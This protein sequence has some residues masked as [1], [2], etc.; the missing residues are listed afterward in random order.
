MSFTRFGASGRQIYVADLG[1]SLLTATAPGLLTG[2]I[3]V[4]VAFPETLINAADPVNPE[5]TLTNDPLPLVELA[6]YSSW[7]VDGSG[8]KWIVF[9]DDRDIL[10]LSEDRDTAGVLTRDPTEFVSTEFGGY[11]G[12]TYRDQTPAVDN[13]GSAP[14]IAFSSTGRTETGA[15]TVAAVDADGDSLAR[16]RVFINNSDT[17]RFTPL[18]LPVVPVGRYN[19]GVQLVDPLGTVYCDSIRTLAENVVANSNVT[20]SI[21]FDRWFGSVRVA[22]INRL[23]SD[24][25]QALFGYEVWVGGSPLRGD[26]DQV[27]LTTAGNLP[28]RFVPVDCL[29]AGTYDI[30]I[31]QPSWQPTR[32]ARPVPQNTVVTPGDT[33]DVLVAVDPFGRS[34]DEE[35]RSDVA[36]V[37]GLAEPQGAWAE[38][39]RSFRA[40]ARVLQ[41]TGSQIWYLDLADS[42]Y[43]AV[44]ANHE[45]FHDVSCDAPA[46]SPDGQFLAFT[47]DDPGGSS[48]RHVWVQEVGTG[49]E[50]VR[51]PNPGT[52]A[53]VQCVRA[54]A[55]P[56][57]SPDGEWIVVGLTECNDFRAEKETLWKVKVRGADGVLQ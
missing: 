36:A 32:F 56:S 34:G 9:S 15:L 42:T 6:D 30:K 27:I 38:A 26:D 18:K 51:I 35:S 24:S 19:V 2:G 53:N 22:V 3:P 54:A 21:S 4:E 52:S 23:T 45:T 25:T 31:R 11:E 20:R 43:H 40:A 12:A 16:G 14:R 29:T 44:T 5:T 55:H 46:W 50:P 1:D 28:D 13:S 7:M 8:N 10:L 33:V 48:A 49:L 41:G 57:W 17:G 39:R 37:P 47:C